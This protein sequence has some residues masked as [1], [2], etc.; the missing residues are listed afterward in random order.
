M[1]KFLTAIDLLRA[2]LRPSL[3]KG[4]DGVYREVRSRTLA[5]LVPIPS[6]DLKI[7]N[8]RQAEEVPNV[9]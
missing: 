9:E 6:K 1:L 8:K 7:P 2:D 3:A 4:K 5:T